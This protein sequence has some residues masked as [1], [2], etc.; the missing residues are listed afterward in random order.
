MI[1]A[2]ITVSRAE[3]GETQSAQ[4]MAHFAQT[5]SD[6]PETLVAAGLTQSMPSLGRC[7]VPM[8]AGEASFVSF[9]EVQLLDVGEVTISVAGG[10]Q[11]EVVESASADASAVSDDELGP[12]GDETLAAAELPGSV[13]G[14]ASG[15]LAHELAAIAPEADGEDLEPA[16]LEDVLEPDAP[17][18]PTV[19]QPT[20]AISLA[21]RAF[22]SISSFASGVVYTSRDRSPDALRSGASYLLEVAGSDFLPG[23]ELQ[24]E[25]PRQL[26]DVTLGGEPLALVEAIPVGR[27]LDVTWAVEPGIADT[28]IPAAA[29]KSGTT[30]DIIV[31]ELADAED[32]TV[33][34]R[35][36]FA[37]DVG[38]ATIS[39]EWLAGLEGDGKILL[40][41]RRALG[42]PLAELLADANTTTQTNGTV[43]LTFDFE[44]SVAVDFVP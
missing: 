21:P 16:A 31:V 33:Q 42:G 10:R 38:S 40:H 9:G 32:G 1:D 20:V 26:R 2:T 35:C 36:A 27:P 18:Q 17:L 11:V 8:R 30:G 28:A 5:P 43:R 13:E 44:T 6:A 34:V 24:A 39:P 15:T 37:D 7:E 19:L 25:A 41:R 29:P 14:E 22:P 12:L 4:A 23:F 3:A